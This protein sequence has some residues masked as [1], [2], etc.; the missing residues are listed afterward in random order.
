MR[1]NLTVNYTMD[2]P[3][4]KLDTLMG[5]DKEWEKERSIKKISLG[6]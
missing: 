1:I 3:N 6:I 4:C 5:S 2:L